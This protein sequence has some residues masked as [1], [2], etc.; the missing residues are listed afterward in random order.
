VIAEQLGARN[1]VVQIVPPIRSFP[2]LEPLG[3]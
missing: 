2:G 3:S 1:P